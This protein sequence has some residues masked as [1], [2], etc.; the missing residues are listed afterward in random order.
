MEEV[1]VTQLWMLG[2]VGIMVAYGI[3]TA[4]G[5]SKKSGK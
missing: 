1:V 4:I 2:V 3:A 5:A